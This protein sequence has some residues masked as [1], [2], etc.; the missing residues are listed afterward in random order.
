MILEV[1]SLIEYS[2]EFANTVRVTTTTANGRRART[3]ATSGNPITS[4]QTN[5]AQQRG[6]GNQVAHRIFRNPS[7]AS[8]TMKPK[9]TLNSRMSS[10]TVSNS[11]SSTS[12]FRTS[13][14]TSVSMSS[15]ASSS[16]IPVRVLPQWIPFQPRSMLRR[17]RVQLQRQLSTSHYFQ[18][19]D[20]TS[21]IGFN[22][23]DNSLNFTVLGDLSF[24]SLPEIISFLDDAQESVVFNFFSTAG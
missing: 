5:L 7:S 17:L 18:Y 13:T 4:V 6:L 20:P 23:T 2:Q 1:L 22:T 16:T 12:S 24:N 14:A 21:T 15:T 9:S 11:V 19:P 3:L 10:S 8:S